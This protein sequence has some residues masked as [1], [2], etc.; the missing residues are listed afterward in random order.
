MHGQMQRMARVSTRLGIGYSGGMILTCPECGTS[1]FVDDARIPA[2]GRVV[3]CSSC[4]ARWT[5]TPEAPSAPAPAPPPPKPAPPPTAFE[6]DNGFASDLEIAGPSDAGFTQQA[7]PAAKAAPKKKKP[8]GGKVGIWIGAAVAVVALVTAAIV[9][10]GA[11]VAAFPDAEAAYAGVGLPAT[12]LGLSIENVKAQP[13]FEGGRAALAVSGSIRNRQAKGATS[14]SL[15][16]S[17]LDRT[18]KPVAAKVVRPLN[19]AIPAGAARHFAVTIAD[20]P[21]SVHDLEVAFEGPA[22]AP[23][24]G[25]VRV[26][27]PAAAPAAPKAAPAAPAQEA[28]PLPAGSPDALP[29]HG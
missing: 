12:G 1:Y 10:R 26:A 20:P 22:A 19:A 13:I 5:A 29:H 3:K 14:P 16:I 8:A 15:R 17:L 11:V 6:A 2:A 4:D 24:P 25:A 18:G 23:A 21:A 27:P 28:K 7:R 9:F